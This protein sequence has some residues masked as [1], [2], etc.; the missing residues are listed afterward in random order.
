MKIKRLLVLA[1]SLILASTLAGCKSSKLFAEKKL[2]NYTLTRVFNEKTFKVVK[3]GN[4]FAITEED[5][6]IRSLVD[7]GNVTYEYTNVDP[8]KEEEQTPTT[9]KA[10]TTTQ[11]QTTTAQE[12]TTEPQTTV[13]GTTSVEQTTTTQE[14][15]TKAPITSQK[16]DEEEETK[17]AYVSSEK[18]DDDLLGYTLV[19][20]NLEKT[21]LNGSSFTNLEGNAVIE[22][23]LEGVYLDELTEA[24]KAYSRG[25][26]K[27]DSA[28]LESASGVPSKLTITITYNGK[29]NTVVWTFSEVGSSKVEVAKEGY[30]EKDYAK[31]T[32]EKNPVVTLEFVG[33]GKIYV[34]LFTDSKTDTNAMNY[35]IY[36]FKKHHYRSITLDQAADKNGSI[37]FGQSED[38][39]E[40]SISTDST[41]AVS[42][43]RGTLSVVVKKDKANTS[44]LLLNALA[45]TEYNTNG[46]TPVGGIV[47]GFD[48]LDALSGITEE[49]ALKLK[50]KVSIKYN[51]YTY[52]EPT[53][54]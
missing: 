51:G 3:D 1:L 43:V 41:P 19:L 5:G 15:T 40:R 31:Y 10:Q 4:K 27:A 17:V 37:F 9:T 21:E 42:N 7:Y 13:D 38:A 49:E 45:N 53:F 11:A 52:T 32:S 50:V 39:P 36:L 20:T 47:D 22:K 18:V 25:L 30:A 16:D 33:Y 54:A 28:T 23:Y 29:V 12:T 35:F 34:Q 48:V 44:E 8:N 46:Y 26:I 2:E 14:T 24:S 6:T